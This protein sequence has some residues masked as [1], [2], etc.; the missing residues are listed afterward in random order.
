MQKKRPLDWIGTTAQF[1]RNDCSICGERPYDYNKST[2][3]FC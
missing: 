2:A 3:R 1:I